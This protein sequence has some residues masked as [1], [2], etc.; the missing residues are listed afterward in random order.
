MLDTAADAVHGTDSAASH[1]PSLSLEAWTTGAGR[2]GRSR[3]LSSAR[4]Y[5]R[6]CAFSVSLSILGGCRVARRDCP[7]VFCTKSDLTGADGEGGVFIWRAFPFGS[8]VKG[9]S[10]GISAF[11][12]FNSE[13]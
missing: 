13:Y 8:R 1:S 2:G 6:R 10:K 3:Q 11:G 5:K 7:A 12:K 9:K 4:L